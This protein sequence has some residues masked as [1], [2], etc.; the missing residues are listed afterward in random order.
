M[1]T[2]CEEIRSSVLELLSKNKNNHNTINVAD[3]DALLFSS[4]CGCSAS[5]LLSVFLSLEK[6][7]N[8]FLP[9][10][11]RPEGDYTV[12]NIVEAICQQQLREKNTFD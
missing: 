1:Y 5:D 10:I 11:V 9:A 3:H 4:A 2:S 8:V 7:H 12:N 6:Q